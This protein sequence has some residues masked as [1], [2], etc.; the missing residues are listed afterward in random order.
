VYI[1]P[2]ERIVVLIDGP[3]L[4]GTMK[5]LGFDMDYKK[6]LAYLRGRGRLVRA[7]YFTAVLEQDDFVSVR[8]LIDWLEYNG[9]TL[10]TKRVREFIDSEGRRRIK[11]S[12]HVDLAVHAMQQAAGADHFIF[13]TGDGD[14]R[15]LVAELQRMGK[16][17]TVVS[18]LA[19]ETPMLADELRR[20]ADQFVDLVDLQAQI[21]RD[22]APRRT[23]DQPRN[24]DDDPYDD[25]EDS[26]PLPPQGAA[27]SPPV[28]ATG[29]VVETRTRRRTPSR[30]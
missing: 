30:S 7:L 26:S 1:T 13:F 20:Q 19:G 21:G 2:T 24:Q 11:S 28:P 4:Y 6:L 16:R 9:Y 25:V 14:F 23:A 17:V 5:S 12:M 3:N 29:V 10:V 22:H 15:S 27:S 8:P 18:T